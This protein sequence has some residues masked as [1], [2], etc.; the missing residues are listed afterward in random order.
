VSVDP[1]AEVHPSAVIEP[2]ATIMA[3]ATVGPFSIIG[4]DVVLEER[5][6]V[7]SHAVVTGITRVGEETVIFPGSVI[8]EIPQDLKIQPEWLI[9]T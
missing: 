5:V 6:E 7:K 9:G 3:G 8:G 2:G 4:A 1:K